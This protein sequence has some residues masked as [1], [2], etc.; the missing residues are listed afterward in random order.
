MANNQRANLGTLCRC[1]CCYRCCCCCCCCFRCCCCWCCSCCYCC[2]CW[3]FCFCFCCCCCCCRSCCE[4]DWIG[5][6]AAKSYF[7]ISGNFVH[8]VTN[9]SKPGNTRLI[10]FYWRPTYGPKN[11]LLNAISI[12]VAINRQKTL[13][14]AFDYPKFVDSLLTT[15]W[16]KSFPNANLRPL[17]YCATNLGSHYIFF[18]A[19]RSY[20]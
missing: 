12:T 14:T 17:G 10:T 13:V 6:N 16:C 19:Y 3:C 2:C 18:D 9:R 4:L 20:R 1:C 7:W 15:C 11:I 5:S 8:F